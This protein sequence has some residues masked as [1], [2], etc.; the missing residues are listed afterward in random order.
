ML[1]PRESRIGNG[2]ARF[3]CLALLGWMTAAGGA[4]A[5]QQERIISP[6]V[7]ADGRVTFRFRAPNAKEV[8]VAMEG[9]GKPQPMTKD[10]RGVWSVTTEPLV[11][12][13]YGYSI[14]MDGVSLIDPGNPEV[15]PNRLSPGSEAHVPGPGS[16]PWETNDVPHGVVHHHFYHSRVVGDNRDFYVYT[17]PNYDPGTRNRYPV[18]YLLHGYSDDASGWLSVGRANVILDNLIAQGKAKPMLMVMTLGYGAPEILTGGWEAVR[19]Q[20]LWKKNYE[21]FR[22]ALLEEV[23]PMVERNYRVKADPEWRAIA[24]LSMGGSETLFVGLNNLDK[25][26]YLG[27]FSSG[28]MGDDYAKIYP[29]LD[30]SAN[31][32]V[33]VF[34]Q[35]CGKDDHLLV[36]NEKLRDWLKGKGVHVAWVESPGAHWWPVWRRNLSDLLPQLFQETRAPARDAWSQGV[37]PQR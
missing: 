14:V 12:D 30:S 24:G 4:L 1:C 37:Q 16:L 23:I 29:G 15:K 8:S 5:Q 17:P 32:K 35:S 27:A 9:Y 34:W 28:G 7:S 19:H 26:A 21:K 6:E 18:L 31:A 22:D 13:Y 36:A 3:A 25:F 33:R 2:H 11:P 10:E 20:E